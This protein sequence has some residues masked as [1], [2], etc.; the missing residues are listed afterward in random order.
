MECEGRGEVQSIECPQPG[1]LGQ[2]LSLVQDD[3]TDFYKFPVATVF[4]E[5]RPDGKK[6]AP[7]KLPKSA[8]AAQDRQGFDG[9]DGR[10]E[11]PILLQEPLCSG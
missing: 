7:G 5:S 2:I 11:E 1:F 10:G 9:G 8:S 3:L 6:I 4:I